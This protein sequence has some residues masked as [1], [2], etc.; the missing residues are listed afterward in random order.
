VAD[1]GIMAWV[2]STEHLVGMIKYDSSSVGEAGASLVSLKRARGYI[3]SFVKIGR[4]CMS[5]AKL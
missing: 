3:E 4:S 5:F 1:R 2:M